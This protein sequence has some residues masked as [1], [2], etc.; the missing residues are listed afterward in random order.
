GRRR[1][2]R[3]ESD[4]VA[5][6]DED[7][8]ASEE[9]DVSLVAVADHALGETADGLD[10]DFGHVATRDAVLGIDGGIDDDELPAYRD[11]EAEEKGG[12]ES[13]R[14]DLLGQPE[15]AEPGEGFV[16]HQLPRP[17]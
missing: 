15:G 2:T 12:H 14:D 9:G 1:E 10:E 17:R 4:Q 11:R 7:E 3:N 16:F 5:D 8:E 13:R 6:Q